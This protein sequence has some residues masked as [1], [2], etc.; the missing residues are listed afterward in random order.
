[1][2]DDPTIT[3]IREAR[4]KISAAVNHD[5]RNLVAHYRELQERHRERLVSRP[6]AVVERQDENVAN[7]KQ[8]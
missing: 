6:A 2:K 4:H 3:A 1:M 8:R 7:A 5:P